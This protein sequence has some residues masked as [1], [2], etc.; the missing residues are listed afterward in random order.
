VLPAVILFCRP[1]V[2]PFLETLNSI[3]SLLV[4]R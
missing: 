3:F 1:F 4:V 2:C